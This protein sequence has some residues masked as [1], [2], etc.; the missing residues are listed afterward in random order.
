MAAEFMR[1]A[2]H[3]LRFHLTAE[4]IEKAACLRVRGLVEHYGCSLRVS[5][6]NKWMSIVNLFLE[7]LIRWASFVQASDVGLELRN[8]AIPLFL[9]ILFERD[10]IDGVKLAIRTKAQGIESPRAQGS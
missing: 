7:M 5:T 10:P 3:A 9:E 2:G 6:E 1:L 8:A 4:F